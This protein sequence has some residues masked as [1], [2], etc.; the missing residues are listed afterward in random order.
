MIS[1]SYILSIRTHKP[2][3]EATH[4]G[5]QHHRHVAEEIHAQ[6]AEVNIKELRL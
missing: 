4:P 2:P 6:Q 1:A 3:I 5:G